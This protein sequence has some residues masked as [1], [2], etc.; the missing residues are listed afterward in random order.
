MPVLELVN[1]LYGLIIVLGTWN[2]LC[3]WLGLKDTSAVGET[4][5]RIDNLAQ[6]S[7]V[8]AYPNPF[9]RKVAQATSSLFL[10]SEPLAQA[11][12]LA[13]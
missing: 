8:E 4:R 7:L 9:S 1:Y 6:A 10:A 13:W 5:A 12:G 11:K 3:D 2:A